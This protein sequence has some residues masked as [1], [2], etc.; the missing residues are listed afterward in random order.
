VHGGVDGG[1]NLGPREE[2][3]CRFPPLGIPEGDDKKV[4]KELPFP[5]VRNDC[6]GV[7]GKEGPDLRGEGMI[8]IVP[9]SL[10]IGV[11]L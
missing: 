7:G 4:I 8:G 10:N 5:F 2:L 6:L 3:S 9:E 1:S 11:V